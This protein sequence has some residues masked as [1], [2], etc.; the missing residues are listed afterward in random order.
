MN[1]DERRKSELSLEDK[2]IGLLD[3]LVVVFLLGMMT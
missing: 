1:Y 2:G 3:F